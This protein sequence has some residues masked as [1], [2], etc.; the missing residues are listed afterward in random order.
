MHLLVPC[1]VCSMLQFVTQQVLELMD[2]AE[3]GFCLNSFFFP[4]LKQRQCAEMCKS[5]LIMLSLLSNYKEAPITVMLR[6]RSPSLLHSAP[7]PWRRSKFSAEVGKKHSKQGMTSLNADKGK[8]FSGV[9]WDN[10]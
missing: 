3:C 10:I 7:W 2:M 6:L 8:I 9:T 4:P 5:F 1:P